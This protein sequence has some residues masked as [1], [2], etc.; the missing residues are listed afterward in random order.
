ML[1]GKCIKCLDNYFSLKIC[2]VIK[3]CL[4][5]KAFN[6]MY[7]FFKT[8]HHSRIKNIDYSTL[9]IFVHF[10]YER[11]NEIIVLVKIVGKNI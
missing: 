3:V 11:V 6:H 7:R 1:F 2:E 9:K 8:L 4:F 10:T 5:F